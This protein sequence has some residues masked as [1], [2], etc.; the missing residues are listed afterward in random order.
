MATL[1]ASLSRRLLRGQI[2]TF[3]IMAAIFAL[4]TWSLSYWKGW[5]YLINFAVCT[6]IVTTY[7]AYRDPALLRRRMRSGP[8][9]EREPAQKLIQTINLSGIVGL[10]I[11][12]GLDH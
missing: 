5:A 12:P 2:A 1:P 6:F 3:A 7:V 4:S 8:A 11:V 10:I 9:A